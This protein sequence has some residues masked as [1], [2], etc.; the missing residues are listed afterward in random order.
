MAIHIRR[1]EFI[2]ALG[3]TAVAWPLAPRAEQPEPMRRI[4]VMIEFDEKDPEAKAYSKARR[5]QDC[6]HCAEGTT[7]H[8][9]QIRRDVRSPG[10]R[11]VYCSARIGDSTG[12]YCRNASQ[13][14]HVHV[15]A[16]RHRNTHTQK[17]IIA[18]SADSGP[19]GERLPK[20]QIA[21]AGKAEA[22]QTVKQLDIQIATDAPKEKLLE[23]ANM[24]VIQ[25]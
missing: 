17:T 14:K 6:A 18:R 20:C 9:S 24:A 13:K 23:T 22:E 19:A 1:R 2:V 11:I 5:L 25:L 15:R 12:I 7:F 21:K 16:G 8:R 10:E 3:G 4:G